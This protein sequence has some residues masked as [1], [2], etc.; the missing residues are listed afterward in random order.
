M[1]R[2]P[3]PPLL[4]DLKYHIPEGR[5]LRLRNGAGLVVSQETVVRTRC[6]REIAAYTP[7]VVVRLYNRY[8]TDEERAKPDN[9]RHRLGAMYYDEERRRWPDLVEICRNCRRLVGDR[10]D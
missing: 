2:K 7:L 1:A 10:R 8:E 6:D 9:R 4:P 5:V 3:T